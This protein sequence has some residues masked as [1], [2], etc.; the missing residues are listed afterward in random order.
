MTQTPT[1][2][3]PSTLKLLSVLRRGGSVLVFV[4][5]CITLPFL[6]EEEE[7]GSAAFIVF[8]MF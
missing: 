3:I 4:L 2:T 8:R 7:A 1:P 5:D 6:D